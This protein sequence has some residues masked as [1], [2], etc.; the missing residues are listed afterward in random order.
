MGTVVDFS[1]KHVA[2][3]YCD[4]A[5][6]SIHWLVNSWAARLGPNHPSAVVGAAQ[7]AITALVETVG[8]SATIRE[9]ELVIDMIRDELAPELRAE[10]VAAATEAVNRARAEVMAEAAETC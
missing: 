10:R 6:R 2:Q 7:G 1:G 5:R 3:N 9:L 8:P 4:D